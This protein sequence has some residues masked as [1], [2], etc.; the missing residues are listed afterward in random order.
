LLPQ[1]AGGDFLQRL[2]GFRAAE[3]ELRVLADGFHE[4]VADVDAVMEIQGLPVE[5]ARRLPYL[6]ELLDFRMVDVEIAGGRAT[7]QRALAD[8]QRQRVHHADEGND[9]RGLPVL[10]D[11][12]A[13][14]AHRAPIG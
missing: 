7:P 9:A 11:L 14:R 1:L 6:E 13:D 8:R 3:R 10:A 2:A 5:V 4:L 12:F